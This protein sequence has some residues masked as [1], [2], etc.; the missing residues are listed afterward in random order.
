MAL[1]ALIL[2]AGLGTRLRPLTSVRAKAAV[3]VNGVPL[4]R[5]VMSWL[6]SEGVTDLVINLHHRPRSIAA[7]VGDGQDGG[8]R[9]RYS[10]ENPVLGSAGGP[11]HALPLLTD[12]AGGRTG[13][14]S[15]VIVNGDTL[16]ELP[17]GGL[18]DTHEKCGARVTMSL[19]PNPRPDVYGGVRVED[20]WITGF[21][22]P[23][24]ER[25][26]HFI[27]VQAARPD[28]FG[29][30]EDGVPLESVNWLYP[31]LMKESPTSV[32]AFIV[33]APFSDIGTPAVYL[34]TSL[35]LAAREGDH[36]V[37]ASGT[38]I[39]QSAVLVR[40]TVWDGAAIGE[41]AV[42]EDCIVCDGVRVA[43][44]SSYSRCAL[45]PFGGQALASDEWR[46]GDLLIRRF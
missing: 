42:L 37:S 23:G 39:H 14:E 13:T 3:P 29:D 11:R 15:F 28:A 46:E 36:L 25:S 1:R 38:D 19:I 41:N 24:S 31:R 6:V 35:D 33:D 4:V 9:V 22:R 16:T 12:R 18:M 34:Q 10:W 27:G 43:P 20:G 7:V 45:V 17:I 44:G 32:A 8:A 21:T 30:L 5:R 2:A 40:T 26:Y